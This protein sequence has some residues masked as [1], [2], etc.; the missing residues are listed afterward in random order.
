M[1]PELIYRE[2]RKEDYKAL[3]GLGLLAGIIGFLVAWIVFPGNLS[4]VAVVFA[5]IPLVYPLNRYFFEDEKERAPHLQ[6]V[7]VYGSLFAGLTT[8]FFILGL[9]FQDAFEL[10]SQ[11]VGA[12]GF[13]TQAEA[14][15]T[16]VFL[17]NITVFGIILLAALFVGSAGAFVLTWNASVLGFFFATLVKDFRSAEEFFSCSNP[18]P[19][20]L[21]YLPHTTFEMGGFIVAG[22]AGTLISAAVY[23]KDFETELW[24]DYSKLVLAGVLLV[25][26]GAVL[27]TA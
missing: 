7:L 9:N 10:Q 14:A 5:A 17:N 12:A 6:E 2:E 20:P 18:D 19:S 16:S 23:R 21:C 1:L 27:E 13:A 22:V 11:L 24:K 3:Y 26:V 4:I 25:L 15:F 8:A